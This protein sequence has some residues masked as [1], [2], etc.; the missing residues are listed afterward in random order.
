MAEATNPR[1]N[2]GLNQLH[3]TSTKRDH[4]PRKFLVPKSIAIL[5]FCFS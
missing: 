5:K 2:Q 3:I 1:N 4:S